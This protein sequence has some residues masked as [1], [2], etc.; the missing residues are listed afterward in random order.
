MWGA[1]AGADTCASCGVEHSRLDVELETESPDGELVPSL[2][3]QPLLWK[4]WSIYGYFVA[5]CFTL[6]GDLQQFWEDDFC[7][8][9]TL[10]YGETED[11]TRFYIS[12]YD[13]YKQK[14]IVAD[15]HIIYERV[16]MVTGLYFRPNTFHRLKYLSAK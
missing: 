1:W 9:L 10:E 13:I 12:N 11:I 3:W 16:V 6:S 4:D 8:S 14:L 7:S 2:P 15:A 5:I